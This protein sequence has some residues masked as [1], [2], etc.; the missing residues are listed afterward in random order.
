MRSIV[1]SFLS[2]IFFSSAWARSWQKIEIP[3]A[4]C[5]NGEAY[6]VFLDY[7][8]ADKLVVE[9]MAGGVC[10]N[11][12]SCYG[13]TAL[14]RLEPLRTDPTADLFSSEDESNPWAHHSM[15]YFPYCTGDVFANFHV[16]TYRS[17]IPLYHYG[18]QNVVLALEYLYRNSLISFSSVQDLVV[19]GASAGA[20]GAFV[21]AKNIAEYVPFTAQKT[22]ISDSPGLHFGKNFWHKFSNQM[23]QDFKNYM[24]R[25][26]FEY[27]LDDG[28]IAP[29]MGSVFNKLLTW[30][31]AILQSTRDLVMSAVFGGITPNEHRKLVLGPEGIG[32]VAK[33][34]KNV[35]TWIADNPGHT[36]LLNPYTGDMRSMEGETAWN[37]TVR[38]Y[39][40]KSILLLPR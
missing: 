16:A 34:F 8:D 36:F 1:L 6:S 23:N 30:N 4:F 39:T 11:D 13:Q 35:S 3:G 27:S 21:H 24:G 12:L 20:I 7:K 5:G 19:W 28:M 10:W 22:L 9:F 26:G 18:Y 32:Q 14:T 25:A 37:F 31:I 2:L 29:R 15:I 17:G 33:G 38:V 40:E